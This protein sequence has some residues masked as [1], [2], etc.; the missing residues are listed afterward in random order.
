MPGDQVIQR[1]TTVR[2]ALGPPGRTGGVEHVSQVTGDDGYLRVGLGIPRP[3]LRLHVEA[4]DRQRVGQRRQTGTQ[5]SLG[6]QQA[7]CGIREHERQTLCRVCRIERHVS[8]AG[9]E[10]GQQADDHL[11]RALQAQPHALLGPHALLDQV[12]RQAVGRLIE[13]GVSQRSLIGQQ[14]HSVRCALRHGLEALD[15]IGLR[16]GI[17]FGA[18]PVVDDPSVLLGVEQVERR[19]RLFAVLD[20]LR[21]DAAQ[22]FAHLHHGLRLEQPRRVFQAADDLSVTFAEC[23]L[24]VEFSHWLYALQHADVEP[25]QFQIRILMLLP[26]EQHL[27]H[28]AV[29]QTA[30][31]IEQLHHLIE[32]QVLMFLSGKRNAARLLQPTGHRRA[33]GAGHAQRQGIDEE[34][35]QPFQLLLAAVRRGHT[36]DHVILPRQAHQQQRPGRQKV[37]EQ[38]GALLRSQHSEPCRQR[39]VKDQRHEAAAVILG[40]RSFVIGG[41][42][43]Q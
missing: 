23:Q 39:T 30:R 11:R 43:Q 15:A 7:R 17:A 4:A 2:H 29:S 37:H 20:H 35:D 25:G 24:Q 41:Q 32:R 10:D 22:V 9:L 38:R 14:R 13:F 33:A 19:Q 12:I 40:R 31:R 3:A 27:K 34:P 16:R 18:V 21:E 28:R 6:Q 26:G 1:R 8:G 42:L 36:D 5:C